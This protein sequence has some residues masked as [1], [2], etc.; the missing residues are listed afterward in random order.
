MSDS[1][2]RCVGSGHCQS[3][4]N[5]G[6]CGSPGDDRCRVCGCNGVTYDAIQVACVAGIRAVQGACGVGAVDAGVPV[7][8][9]SCGSAS[10]C[11]PGAQCC[12]LTGKCY[13]SSEPWR[14][15]GQPDGAVLDCVS[16]GECN[17]GA[18]GGGGGERACD[19]E[20]CGGP[21]LCRPRGSTASC[22]GEVQSVCGCDG[23]SYVNACWALA[24]STRVAHTGSCP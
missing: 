11:S 2:T 18:G 6:F 17:S 14:C 15:V 21:G 24:A 23:Q 19:G 16:T 8:Q 9:V 22:G 12:A 7:T 10:Q 13:P 5:C 3:I 4:T 1:P 20:G